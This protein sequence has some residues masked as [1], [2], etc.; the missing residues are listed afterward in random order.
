[1]YIWIYVITEVTLPRIF[2]YDRNPRFVMQMF[3]KITNLTFLLS[4]KR[5]KNSTIA[6]GIWHPVTFTQREWSLESDI[7]YGTTNC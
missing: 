1:M 7:E 2:V 6:D 3:V 4:I 5:Q